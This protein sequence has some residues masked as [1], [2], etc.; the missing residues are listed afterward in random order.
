MSDVD[1]E[2]GVLVRCGIHSSGFLMPHPT[3]ELGYASPDPMRGV[4]VISEWIHPCMFLPISF[5]TRGPLGGPGITK[6]CWT[7]SYESP[8][9]FTCVTPI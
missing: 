5:L 8:N 9:T 2:C 3:N 4:E 7:T 1:D 6:I